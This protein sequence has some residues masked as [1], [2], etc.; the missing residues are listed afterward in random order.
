MHG[1]Y[2][3]LT[4]APRVDEFFEAWQY[5][6]VSPTIYHDFKQFGGADIKKGFRASK[7]TLQPDTG[8][9]ILEE[10]RI[11]PGDA[12]F[13]KGSKFVLNT[14]GDKTAIYLSD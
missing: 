9:S 1:Y 2:L 4:N 5:G 7:L 10:S 11:P 3:A 8:N 14:H 12:A 13:Q 6:P